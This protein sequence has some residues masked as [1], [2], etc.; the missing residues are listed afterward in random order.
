MFPSM[1]ARAAQ[2]A[3]L[4]QISSGKHQQSSV[5][6]IA[7]S[8][9]PDQNLSFACACNNATALA[10]AECWKLSYPVTVLPP[11]EFDALIERGYTT[12]EGRVGDIR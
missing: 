8:L 1:S 10:I 12:F 3:L 7:P 4:D 9:R 2:D 6:R 11:D 5:R